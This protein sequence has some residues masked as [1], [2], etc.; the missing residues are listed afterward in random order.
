MAPYL[1]TKFEVWVC[2]YVDKIMN[3]IRLVLG[4]WALSGVGEGSKGGDVL[5]VWL[6]I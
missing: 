4:T 6:E 1:Y 3:K 5:L 2:I